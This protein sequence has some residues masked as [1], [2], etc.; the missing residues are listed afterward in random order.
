MLGATETKRSL[1]LS[2]TISLGNTLPIAL[3]WMFPPSAAPGYF[4]GLA[5]CTGLM[6]F[7]ALLATALH[8]YCRWEN[9]RADRE[10]GAR[11]DKEQVESDEDVRFRLFQ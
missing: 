2:V 9:K 10:Y 8:L 4:V 5:L 7:A 6:L 11:S 1:G 3:P